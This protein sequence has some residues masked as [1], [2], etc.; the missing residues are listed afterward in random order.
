MNFQIGLI[1][2]D[3]QDLQ[4]FLLGVE[5]WYSGGIRDFM[6]EGFYGGYGGVGG[7][8]CGDGV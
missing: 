4:D 6:E 1:Y 5:E 3:G 8:Y 7:V 2:M